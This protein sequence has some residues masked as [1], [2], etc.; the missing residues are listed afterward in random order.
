MFTGGWFQTLPDFYAQTT[1]LLH[2]FR[3]GGGVSSEMSRWTN[4][5]TANACQLPSENTVEQFIHIEQTLRMRQVDP[6][7]RTVPL[8]QVLIEGIRNTIFTQ[9]EAPMLGPSGSVPE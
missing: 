7:E 9:E 3:Q 5:S 1:D 6:S 8:H 4:G 2:A